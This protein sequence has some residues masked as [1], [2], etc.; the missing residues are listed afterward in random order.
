MAKVHRRTCE[1][2]FEIF[3]IQTDT[4]EVN[5]L[6]AFIN[7]TSEDYTLVGASVGTVN[8]KWSLLNETFFKL[9]I[10]DFKSASQLFI[11]KARPGHP[12]ETDYSIAATNQFFTELNTIVSPFTRSK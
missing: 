1:R 6:I 10:P 3:N 7:N 11:F 5:R 12:N 2:Q 4:A 9:G 8:A